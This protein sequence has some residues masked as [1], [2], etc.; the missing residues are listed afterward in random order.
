VT[1]VRQQGPVVVAFD[2]DG[3]LTTVDTF[4]L[5]LTRCC[6]RMRLCAAG[7]RH[8]PS[9][10]RGLSGG[11]ARDQAK[12]RVLATLLAGRDF[13]HVDGIAERLAAEIVE[14]HL[15]PDTTARLAE[16]LAAGHRVLIVSASIDL[17]VRRVANHL[18]VS[19]VLATALHVDQ[20]GRLTGGLNGQN[21][22]GQEKVERIRTLIGA[23]TLAWGYG[24]SAGDKEMLEIAERP[25]WVRKNRLIG[26]MTAAAEGRGPSP[27][28]HDPPREP[29]VG[30]DGA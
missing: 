13:S 2:F 17:Y 25:E 29:L 12:E 23:E 22:R 24:D 11:P 5:F 26:P 30:A 1:A 3:T 19:D 4:R 16:H 10:V 9:L 20:Q 27:P 14:R 6:G 18:G 7:T 8:G 28:S 21:V 15:R